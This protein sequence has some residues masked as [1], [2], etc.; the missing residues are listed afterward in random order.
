MSRKAALTADSISWG[1]PKVASLHPFALTEAG[2]AESF[3]AALGDRLRYDH[4]RGRWLIWTGHRW[5]PDTT[6][7]VIRLALEHVRRAQH[8]ALDLTD[9]FERGK[10]VDHWLKFD[11]RAALDNLLSLAKN[12]PP[13][14]DDGAGWD[15][16]GW[17]LGCANGIVDLRTGA[18]GVGRPEDRITLSTGIS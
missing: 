17:L 15:R 2:A 12:L 4:R 14:A 13:L 8:Q 16:D 9:T 3:A 10:A 1:G 7:G 11:R 5:V 6:G 18:L